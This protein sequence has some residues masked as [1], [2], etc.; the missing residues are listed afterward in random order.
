MSGA[1]VSLLVAISFAAGEPEDGKQL[2]DPAEEVVPVAP[3]KE[4]ADDDEED[5]ALA[6]MAVALPAAPRGQPLAESAP[7]VLQRI[8]RPDGSALE[9]VLEPSGEVVLH[10]VTRAG[11]VL[12]CRTVGA[13]LAMR[14]VEQRDAAGGEV[15]HVAHD[16]S[17]AVVRYVVGADG[18]PRAVKLV[19]PA[20]R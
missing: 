10:E 8:E 4:V 5:V 20:R 14:V 18:E 17:G 16:T 13:L 1:W 6:R 19:A 11:T 9:R 12:S 15:V 2:D 7:V 3:G